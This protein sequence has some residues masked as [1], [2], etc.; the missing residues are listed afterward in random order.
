MTKIHVVELLIYFTCKYA[1]QSKRHTWH[2]CMTMTVRDKCNWLHSIRAISTRI[3]W[4]LCQNKTDDDEEEFLRFCLPACLR[5]RCWHAAIMAVEKLFY[6]TFALSQMASGYPDAR[7]SVL[8]VT[9]EDVLIFCGQV[10]CSTLV[11]RHTHNSVKTISHRVR[12]C[13]SVG[14]KCKMHLN[15]LTA[16]TFITA[17]LGSGLFLFFFSGTRVHP[18]GACR[19]R[20]TLTLAYWLL[21]LLL[22]KAYWIDIASR[23]QHTSIHICICGWQRAQCVYG[24]RWDIGAMSEIRKKSYFLHFLLSHSNR[25]TDARRETSMLESNGIEIANVAWHCHHDIVEPFDMRLCVLRV[26]WT[27][28]LLFLSLSKGIYFV[29]V[30]L[31]LRASC[32]PSLPPPHV[33]NPIACIGI[34]LTFYDNFFIFFLFYY[35]V[36][37][38]L[39]WRCKNSR[40]NRDIWKTL[41]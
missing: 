25:T 35:V 32:W 4:L 31:W 17:S 34:R 38:P 6:L 19:I 39:K 30:G 22:Q 40:N 18:S 37:F 7:V 41:K 21:L 28:L 20:A 5:K 27:S 29:T 36:V 2:I 16:M 23:T 3:Y 15:E 10:L 9:A 14:S 1:C 24:C 8:F 13:R 26:Q 33:S 12:C 11:A